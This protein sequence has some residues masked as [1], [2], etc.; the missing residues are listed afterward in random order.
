[1]DLNSRDLKIYRKIFLKS[2]SSHGP[3]LFASKIKFCSKSKIWT[4]LAKKKYSLQPPAG[5]QKF[6][7]KL[8]GSN[9]PI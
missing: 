2:S 4:V 1:M 9:G 3:K 5:A 8:P 6:E 7:M